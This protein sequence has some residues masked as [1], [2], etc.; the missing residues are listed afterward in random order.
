MNN[1]IEIEEIIYKGKLVLT[2]SSFLLMEKG[3]CIIVGE[4]G[5]GKSSV[6]KQLCNRFHD[7]IC[8]MPQNNNAII[9]DIDVLSNISL[10]QISREKVTLILKTINMGYIVNNDVKKLSGGEKRIISILRSLLS[11]SD[12]VILDE[13]FNDIDR[14]TKK[15]VQTLIEYFGKEKYLIIITHTQ[16][17]NNYQ[18]KYLIRDQKLLLIENNSTS[19]SVKYNTRKL[20]V[21]YENKKNYI[22]LISCVIFILYLTNNII[23]LKIEKFEPMINSNVIFLKTHGSTNPEGTDN[24]Y[25]DTSLLGCLDQTNQKQCFE[26]N[27]VE[28]KRKLVDDIEIS[29]EYPAYVL[30]YYNQDEKEYYNIVNLIEELFSDNFKYEVELKEKIDVLL[31]D[32]ETKN[33]ILVPSDINQKYLDKIKRFN[34]KIEKYNGKKIILSFNSEFYEMFQQQ[35]K[36][37]NKASILVN[38]EM[39]QNFY[40]FIKHNKLDDTII[41]M[42][43]TDTDKFFYELNQFTAIKTFIKSIIIPFLALN[44]VLFVTILM[45]EK[46]IFNKEKILYNY[47]YSLQYLISKKYQSYYL[48]ENIIVYLFCLGL[49]SIYTYLKF[50]NYLV[51]A[52]IILLFIA[53]VIIKICLKKMININMKRVKK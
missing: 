53:V 44:C 47:G 12:I 15:I 30:E 13:P 5:C 21:F 32:S 36:T 46:A 24:E 22:L 6:A 45:L 49:L 25:F 39:K 20:K 9:E 40:D 41:L 42:R 33:S 27:M 23:N 18:M 17:I 35:Y 11:N 38:N 31:F 34:F 19:Q 50:N 8:Y 4:N 14:E 7:V 51:V 3:I 52:T 28:E 29:G 43:N 2:K 1:T 10:N 16:D 26:K 48:R 37:K